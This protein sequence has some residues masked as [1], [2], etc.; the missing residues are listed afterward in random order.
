[1][2]EK[3]DIFQLKVESLMFKGKKRESLSRETLLPIRMAD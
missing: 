3:S 2:Q 1:M